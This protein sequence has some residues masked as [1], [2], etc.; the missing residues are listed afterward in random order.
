MIYRLTNSKDP[1]ILL[2]LTATAWL[3]ILELAE[4][5]G[6]HPVGTLYPSARLDLA[7][8]DPAYEMHEFDTFYG[9]DPQEQP[10]VVRLDDAISLAEVL[11][12][13]FLDYEPLRVPVSYY[14][15]APTNPVFDLRPAIGT[16]STVVE[17]CRQGAFTIEHLERLD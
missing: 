3:G 14:L 11:D 4:A 5:Y 16:I 12:R 9:A 13:A 8:M 7:E 2:N 6:W 1:Q 17:F 15:F 10:H